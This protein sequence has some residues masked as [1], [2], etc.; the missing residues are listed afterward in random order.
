MAKL[1]ERVFMLRSKRQQDD[2]LDRSD[3]WQELIDIAIRDH[4]GKLK[5]SDAERLC[6]ILEALEISDD[7]FHHV[8]TGIDKVTC[9]AAVLEFHTD[10]LDGHEERFIEAQRQVH[11]IQGELKRAQRRVYELQRLESARRESKS[12]W[13]NVCKEFSQLVI[14]GKPHPSLES[15]VTK[16][17]KEVARNAANS[18]RA[19]DELIDQQ[20][21]HTLERLGLLRNVQ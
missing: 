12:K 13:Q 16:R 18:Q 6:E 8:T 10:S 5:E 9:A 11:I 2:E 19:G 15:V 3:I 14:D 17:K 20:V 1:M 21:G 7:A 4:A